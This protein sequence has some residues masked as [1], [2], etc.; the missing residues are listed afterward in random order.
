MENQLVVFN[1][2]NE[3]YGVDIAAV[4]GIVKMQSITSVPHAPSFVEGITNL[5]GKVLPVID[6]RKRFGLPPG[7]VTKDTRI[8]NVEMV[9][10]DDQPSVKVGMVV[11]AVSE[12]LRVSSEDIEPPSSI[13]MTGNGGAA[14][15]AG[16]SNAFITGIAKVNNGPG[17]SGRLVILLDLGKVLSADEQIELQ[18]LEPTR[19][20]ILPTEN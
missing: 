20:N 8:V 14:S 17:S 18:T 5:R 1:L 6:L 7:E 11:D 9:H 4:D 3:N 19:D 16:I 10:G 12:V 2:G 13:V 15:P